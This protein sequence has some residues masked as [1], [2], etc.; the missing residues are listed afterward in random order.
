VSISFSFFAHSHVPCRCQKK[1]YLQ[2]KKECVDFSE[3]A[4]ALLVP[5][6]F[7]EV[8][9]K[10]ENKACPVCK[11]EPMVDVVILDECRHG[12]CY[13]CIHFW[14]EQVEEKTRGQEISACPQCQS[15]KF[16][17]IDEILWKRASL[18]TDNAMRDDATEQ[19][20]KD[21]FN[22]AIA[23][24]NKLTQPSE[25]SENFGLKDASFRDF[26]NIVDEGRL[27]QA[28]LFL[29]QGQAE[30]ALEVLEQAQKIEMSRVEGYAQESI[31]R[32]SD[33]GNEEVVS[34]CVFI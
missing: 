25:A 13:K 12:I 27:S 19:E 33:R 15:T 30:K 9:S 2:H 6:P 14:Q 32:E 28:G 10:A 18:F 4:R 20:Q 26:S 23:E 1:D 16:T 5:K 31:S 7:H 22:L 21:N 24:L 17:D 3:K 34:R 29:R 8:M 11:R